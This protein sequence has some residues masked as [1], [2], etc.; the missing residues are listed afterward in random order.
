MANVSNANS[1]KGLPPKRTRNPKC[2]RCRNH[3]FIVS[4]KGHVGRC[5]FTRCICWKCALITERTK[6]MAKQR[7]IKKNQPLTE[8]SAENEALERPSFVNISGTVDGALGQKATANAC[9]SPDGRNLVETVVKIPPCRFEEAVDK[10]YAELEVPTH[11]ISA[12]EEPWTIREPPQRKLP[13]GGADH[14]AVDCRDGDGRDSYNAHMPWSGSQ[15]DAPFMIGEWIGNHS[16]TVWLTFC[17]RVK[18]LKAMLLQ[19]FQLRMCKV[20]CHSHL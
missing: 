6:I 1:S 2:A 17:F 11:D 16:S 9:V 15:H 12:T 20:E 7:R 5:P 4:L 19:P 18:K 13:H 3:E 8:D 14:S 10:T